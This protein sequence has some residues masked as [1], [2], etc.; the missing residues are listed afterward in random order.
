MYFLD[1]APLYHICT[2]VRTRIALMRH[3]K[4]SD[5]GASASTSWEEVSTHAHTYV[6]ASLS[7]PTAERKWNSKL[8]LRSV[9]ISSL[10]VQRVGTIFKQLRNL[11]TILQSHYILEQIVCYVNCTYTIDRY[12]SIRSNDRY[13]KYNRSVFIIYC[14]YEIHVCCDF[15]L[16]SFIVFFFF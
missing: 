3:V 6:N 11:L 12:T 2:D 10:C 7:S 15:G 16:Y 13:T 8:I 14:Q 4:L 1:T 5:S 9:K